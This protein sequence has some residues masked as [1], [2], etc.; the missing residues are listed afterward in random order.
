MPGIFV[1]G[2]KESE[3]KPKF[4]KKAEANKKRKFAAEDK[5]E[6]IDFSSQLMSD[7]IK[8]FYKAE[9]GIGGTILISD[10]EQIKRNH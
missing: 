3:L 6:T 2:R 7:I 8:H 1:E 4:P 10:I 5:P 9:A